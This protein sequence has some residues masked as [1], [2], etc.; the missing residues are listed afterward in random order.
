MQSIVTRLT[1]NHLISALSAKPIPLHKQPAVDDRVKGIQ[2]VMKGGTKRN[3][4][5]RHMNNTF[6]K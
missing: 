4:G 6:D 2:K 3:V 1:D 5:P